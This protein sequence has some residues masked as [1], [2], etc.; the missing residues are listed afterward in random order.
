MKEVE[1]AAASFRLLHWMHYDAGLGEE[2][3]IPEA[4][5][6]LF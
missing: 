2:E 5:R 3:R 1:R 6:K 4:M